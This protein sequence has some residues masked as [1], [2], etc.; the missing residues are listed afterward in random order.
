MMWNMVLRLVRVSSLVESYTVLASWYL[1]E[2]VAVHK[3]I[4]H[5]LLDILRVFTTTVAEVLR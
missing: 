1:S 4:S 5:L 3:A 2:S